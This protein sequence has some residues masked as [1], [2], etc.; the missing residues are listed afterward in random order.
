MSSQII[1][2]VSYSGKR[3]GAAIYDTEEK[4]VKVVADMAEDADFIA[5]GRSGNEKDLFEFSNFFFLL[6][7]FA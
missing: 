7:S 5:L 2:A 4:E 3:L 6:F 1:C